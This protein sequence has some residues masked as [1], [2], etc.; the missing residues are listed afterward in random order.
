[1]ICRDLGTDIADYRLG[2]PHVGADKG[3]NVFVRLPLLV[4]LADRNAQPFFIVVATLQIGPP[5]ADIDLMRCTCRIRDQRAV[6][7]HRGIEGDVVVVTGRL[8]RIVA[9][10][11]VTRPEGRAGKGPQHVRQHTPHRT[12]QARRIRIGLRYQATCLVEYRACIVREIAHHRRECGPDQGRGLLVR[13]R[14]QP[15]PDHLQFSRIH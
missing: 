3:K 15:A 5:T 4:Q 1:M 2:M 7:E 9:D 6:E 11:D 10:Q 14:P 8:P 13:G 12:A